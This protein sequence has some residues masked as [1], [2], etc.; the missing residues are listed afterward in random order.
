M[1][2]SAFV[3][4]AR[5]VGIPARVVSGWAIKPTDEIQ[6]VSTDQSH[7]WAEV[8]FEGLGW[9][10]FEPTGAGGAPDRTAELNT[11]TVEVDGTD[12]ENS[13]G[14]GEAG[15]SGT[16][17]TPP[18]P[19]DTVTTITQW[20][21]EVRKQKP[22]MVGGTVSTE[23]GRIVSGLQVDI[24]VNETKEHGGTPGRDGDDL[25]GRL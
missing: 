20:P 17:N 9:V 6:T 12:A 16:G 10:T 8:A 2:S 18:P 13:G 23:D 21:A 14:G 1:F 11:E 22:F 5:S 3:V 15:G 25:L 24:Y 4:L 19:E 7:Q